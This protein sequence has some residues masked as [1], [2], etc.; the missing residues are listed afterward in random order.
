MDD[1]TKTLSASDSQ[2][3]KTAAQE[4]KDMNKQS[5][6]YCHELESKEEQR[7]N[8][9]IAASFKR[10]SLGSEL[11]HRFKEESDLGYRNSKDVRKSLD[12]EVERSMINDIG[13]YDPR[14]VSTPNADSY[15][16]N[17][18]VKNN[19][20]SHGFAGFLDDN[21]GDVTYSQNRNDNNELRQSKDYRQTDQVAVVDMQDDTLNSSKGLMEDIDH[22]VTSIKNKISSLKNLLEVETRRLSPVLGDGSVSEASMPN[23]HHDGPAGISSPWDYGMTRN[24]EEVDLRIERLKEEQKGDRHS[25]A[26]SESHK[27]APSSHSRQRS[28]D[29]TLSAKEQG[30]G[31]MKSQLS[32]GNVTHQRQRSPDRYPN[33]GRDTNTVMHKRQRSF[34][35]NTSGSRH[36]QQPPLHQRQTSFDRTPISIASSKPPPYERQASFASSVGSSRPVK[37]P[38]SNHQGNTHGSGRRDV[39]NFDQ[40]ANSIVSSSQQSSLQNVNK[41]PSYVHSMSE[42][43]KDHDSSYSGDHNRSSSFGDKMY[44]LAK[45]PS[46]VSSSSYKGSEDKGRS[47]NNQGLQ[48]GE[49]T[50]KSL[51]GSQELY[52]KSSNTIEWHETR[53]GLFSPSKDDSFLLERSRSEKVKQNMVQLESRP[54]SYAEGLKPPLTKLEK[55]QLENKISR[56]LGDINL[57][58]LEKQS[59]EF[60]DKEGIRREGYDPEWDAIKNALKHRGT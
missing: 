21:Q 2:A 14:M 22:E 52:R 50:W 4:L 48:Q 12:L 26:H 56:S 45:G 30:K 25:Y 35:S 10:L 3:Q 17:D 8:K 42:R 6:E 7:L 27:N 55:L 24:K 31:Q 9:H 41:S 11:S 46:S 43:I 58:D 37:S 60:M 38:R 29:N 44:P 5:V 59:H 36:Q 47:L 18:T 19:R 39:T 13:K 51:K 54:K 1:K 20:L 49:K 53:P 16:G 40:D 57:Q 23:S 15:G 28:Y 33:S 32:L 34:D